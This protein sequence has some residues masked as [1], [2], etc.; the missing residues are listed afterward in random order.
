[1][2]W[3]GADGKVEGAGRLGVPVSW[4]KDIQAEPVRLDGATAAAVG[5]LF[6]VG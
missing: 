5:H 2:T 3:F 1:M 4:L 6:A